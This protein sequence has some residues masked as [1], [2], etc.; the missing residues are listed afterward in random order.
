MS[1][2]QPSTIALPN[3]K[4][5]MKPFFAGVK[6][7]LKK[8]SWPTYKE[9][10]RLFGVVVSVCI[11]LIVVMGVLGFTFETLIHIITRT[12]TGA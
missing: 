10:N 8:V 6:R 9:T 4:R 2:K 3:V 12:G 1:E 5:G 11:L 7:E